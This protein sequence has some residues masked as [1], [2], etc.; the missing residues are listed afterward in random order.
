MPCAQDQHPMDRI[1]QESVMAVMM[2]AEVAGQTEEGYDGML[3]FLE[4]S[5]QA[6]PGF[7]AHASHAVEG[8]W[9]VIELWRSKADSDRFYAEHVA[10]HLPPGIRPKRSVH[11]LH[12]LVM[13][14][15]VEP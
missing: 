11:E 8:G 4:P 14:A 1:T 15:L 13:P 6:A 9:R 12:A 7:V 2:I 10:P 5:V 3:R